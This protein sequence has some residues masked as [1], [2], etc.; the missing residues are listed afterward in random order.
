MRVV[1]T[2]EIRG[3]ACNAWSALPAIIGPACIPRSREP[4]TTRCESVASSRVR[5]WHKESQPAQAWVEEH[6][7]YSCC[8]TEVQIWGFSRS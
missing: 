2:G 8:G 7:V 5:G 6:D 4:K 3:H 1:S